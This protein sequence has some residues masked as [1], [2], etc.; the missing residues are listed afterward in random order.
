MKKFSPKLA[1][2]KPIYA[3]QFEN[4]A[5]IKQMKKERKKTVYKK[6][7]QVPEGAFKNDDVSEI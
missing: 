6:L 2:F 1:S 7:E 5:A 4:K 3:E